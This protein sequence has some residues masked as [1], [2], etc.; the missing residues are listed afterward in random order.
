MSRRDE[1]EWLRDILARIE[2]AKIAEQILIE[3]ETSA[4]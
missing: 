4:N 3:A 1:I 2:A